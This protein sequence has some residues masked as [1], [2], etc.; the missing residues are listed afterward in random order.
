[1]KGEVVKLGGRVR[2]FR[3]QWRELGVSFEVWSWLSQGAPLLFGRRTP[4]PRILRSSKELITRLREPM[5]EF[6]EEQLQLGFIEEWTTPPAVVSPIFMIPKKEGGWRVIIDLRYVNQFQRPGRFK[7]EGIEQVKEVVRRGDFLVK[8]DLKHAFHHIPIREE[9]QKYLGFEVEGTFYVY[10]TLPMGSSSSPMILTKILRPVIRY[11]RDVLRV[12]IVWYVDDFLILGSTKEEA[13]NNLQRVIT[14]LQ[15]LGW[16]INVG[17]TIFT[18][19]RK[20]EFLGF[21]ICTD[22]DPVLRVPYQKRRKARREVV[23]LLTKAEADQVTV[24]DIWKVAGTCGALTKAMSTTPIF[25]RHLLKCIP[26]GLMRKRSS[27]RP[28]RLT[29]EAILDL[30]SWLEILSSWKGETLIPRTCDISVNTD[31][32][33]YRWGGLL[34]ETRKEVKGTW[35]QAWR[36]RHINVKE[37]K[38]V[39]KVVKAFR[40]ELEGKSILLRTDNR[41]AMAYVN[42]MTGRIPELAAIARELIE[43]LETMGSKIQAIYI[44]TVDNVEADALSRS[45]DTHDWCVKEKLFEKIDKK[46]GPHSI[47]RF[48]DKFNRKTKRYNSW[49]YEPEAE[50]VDG[51]ARPW[52]G[53][54]N[55]VVPPIPLLPAV[56]LKL[57]RERAAATVIVPLWPA[58]IWFQKLKAM[59]SSSFTVPRS[60]IKKNG[61]NWRGENWKFVVFRISGRRRVVT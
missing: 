45:K 8:G 53:E 36:R 41:V 58:H 6:I 40:K 3:E 25:L 44:S 21:T 2:E 61:A 38:T 10:R 32:S 47:D 4:T 43:L 28:V 29:K 50:A 15:G 17:K 26:H 23:R 46:F 12:R 22:G 30:R 16:S 39:V 7:M 33:D 59:A 42:R 24:G 34:V 5:R 35:S 54:N 48:A 60:M 55:F 1:M 9:H 11:I 19:A 49:K 52:I 14:L 13:E 56:T 51:L 37:L 20:I 31:S 57:E 18:A 27:G